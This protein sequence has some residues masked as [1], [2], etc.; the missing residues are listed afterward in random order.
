MMMVMLVITALAFDFDGTLVDISEPY[1]R[2]FDETLRNFELP[3]VDP[4]ELYRK[5]ASDLKAQFSQAFSRADVDEDLVQKCVKMHGEIYM[6]IHLKYL[7]K[8]DKALDALKELVSRGYRLGLIGGRPLS[9]VDPELK[10]LGIK[11]CFDFVLTSEAV[12]RPKPAPDIVQRA[13]ALWNIA[14]T[15][16]LVV[17]DSP[18][19]VASAKSAGAFSAGTCSGYF[20]REVIAMAKPDFLLNSVSEVLDIVAHRP[21]KS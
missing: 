19:D 18:D 15:Q 16:I 6:R 12:S 21:G 2:A 1:S 4:I 13:A 3:G 9:Q 8:S 10:F 14:T 17:G 20:S 11:D 7:K 5:G